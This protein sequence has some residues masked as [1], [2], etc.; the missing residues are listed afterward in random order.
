LAAAWNSPSGVDDL[1]APLA[2]ASACLAIARCMSWGRFDLLDLD[3]GD[4][5]PPRLRVLVDDA[6]S[7]C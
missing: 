7:C 4:L 2:L 6:R 1:G 5:D 3:V